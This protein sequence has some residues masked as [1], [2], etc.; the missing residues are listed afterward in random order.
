MK[1]TAHI[2]TMVVLASA[3]LLTAG[4]A[5]TN[6]WIS[7]TRGYWDDYT[8]WSLEVA[9]GNS[10]SVYI[11]NAVSKTVTI[12]FF[13]SGYYPDAMTVSDLD[14]SAPA[15]ATN[16]LELADAG[17]DSALSVLDTVSVSAGGVLSLAS[18]ALSM[19]AVVNSFTN[20]VLSVDGVMVLN[21]N[22]LVMADSGLFVGVDSNASGSCLVA[23]GRLFLTN[24]ATSAIGVSGSGRMI[25]SNGEVQAQSG[26]V[27]VGSGSGSQGALTVAGGDYTCSRLGR[28]ALGME[29]GAVGTVSVTSGSLIL[30]NALITVVGGNG[31]GELNLLT[32]TN[33]L[34]PLSIGSDTGGQG[35]FTVAGGVNNVQGAILLGSSPG[36]TGTVWVTGGQITATNWPAYIG[37]YGSGLLTVSDGSWLGCAITVAS[38][39]NSR[40]AVNLE[41]GTMSLLARL[42]IGNCPEGGVGVVNVAGGGLYVT[43]AAHNAVI[44]VRNGQLNLNGGVLQADALIMTNACGLFV[45]DGG[46]LSVGSL[47][48]D[49]NLDAD[50]DG[51]PNGW[52]QSYGLDPL[53]PADANVDT[54]G[55]GFTN[56]QEYQAGTDPTNSASAFRIV[57]IAQ[58]DDDMRISWTAVGGKRYVLQTTAG[59]SGSFSNGFV[60]LNPAYTA[61]GTGE[62]VMT[63]LH[64]GAAT[65]SPARFYRVRLVP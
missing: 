23:D 47:V 40:G 59:D 19:H 31:I 2:V 22:S 62:V 27:I 12:D 63:V 3:G 7:P 64:P 51:M 24:T 9:P 37:L 45:R 36:A 61:P 4:Y 16:T 60:D 54:D 5:Q 26:F 42:T 29:T 43:N 48:L 49:P 8:K 33:Y 56:L 10:Q 52:E 20:G 41:G 11:T 53:N 1:R 65:G 35:T 14:L 50:G 6:S 38:E 21:S 46:T 55:D 28:L 34:G 30:T 17:T 39:V 15:G 25:V 57:A 44:D 13:T 58:A 32:G 18:S